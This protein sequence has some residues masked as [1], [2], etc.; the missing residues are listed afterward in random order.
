[1]ITE[2]GKISSKLSKNTHKS[3]KYANFTRLPRGR[4]GGLHL[5]SHATQTVLDSVP[6]E[7]LNNKTVKYAILKWLDAKKPYVL[8]YRF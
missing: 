8:K 6:Y 7:A 3:L 5:G 4:G 2:N 1:M